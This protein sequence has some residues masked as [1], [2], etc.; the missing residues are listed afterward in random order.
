MLVIGAS[1]WFIFNHMYNSE[2]NYYKVFRKHA[3]AVVLLYAIYKYMIY[4]SD[5]K[6][7][8]NTLL[9]ITFV[10]LFVTMITPVGVLTDVFTGFLKPLAS[11][12]GRANGIFG[13]PNLA[14]VHMNFT[15]AFVLFFVLKSKRLYLFFLAMVPLV[16]YSG[17]LT[18]SKSTIIIQSGIVGLFF[19]YNMFFFRKIGK[20]ARRNFLRSLVL[21]TIALIYAAP[22][23]KE[24]ASTLNLQ[25]IQRLTEVAAIA[26]GE[27]N[28]ETTTH[29]TVLWKE[30]SLLIAKNPILGYGTSCFS[31]LPEGGLGP[32]NTYL[33]VWGEG[34][35]IPFIALLV[36][37]LSVYYRSYFWI[38]DPTY[39]FL[40]LALTMVIT[41]QMY[42]SA[43]NGLN[44]SEV[45]CMTAVVL[46]LIEIKRVIRPKNYI[47]NN[48]EKRSDLPA[49]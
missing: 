32:H 10:L 42:G 28:E 20:Q 21:I 41:V 25:Q 18:F 16:L 14:G 35:I 36:F 31:R 13:S 34:G 48:E 27:V 33:F 49:A 2:T 30:A 19:L 11:G 26:Q 44:N 9:F 15:L 38:R 12:P 3:P 7:L 1:T 4:V 8:L 6:R 39:R 17:F 37:V 29:R 45:L 5:R 47:S 24:Y 43:H 23:I 40:V 46:A 22:T